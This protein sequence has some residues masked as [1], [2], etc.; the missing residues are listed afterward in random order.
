DRGETD[1]W[2]RRHGAYY[3]EWC[4]GVAAELVGPD[5][6]TRERQLERELDNIWSVFRW[7]LDAPAQGD[8][9]L[10]LRALIALLRSDY[11]LR[12]GLYGWADTLLERARSSA[13]PARTVVVAAAAYWRT[14]LL[15]D[16]EGGDQLA[17]EALRMP[18][19]A[20]VPRAITLSYFAIASANCRGGHLQ[21]ALEL[22]DEGHRALEDAAGGPADHSGLHG[23]GTLIRVTVRDPDG[24]RH[25]ADMA[26]EMAR[27]TGSPQLRMAA[28]TNV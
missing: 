13:L 14:N 28:L 2:R 8:A 9:D 3:A 16:L 23:L 12:S 18:N 4:E 19:A 24:A 11:A 6:Q 26:L 5:E 10:A 17:W 15:D 20:V 22:L 21:E 1:E 7:G 27:A 25:E